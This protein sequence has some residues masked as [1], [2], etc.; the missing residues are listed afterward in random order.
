MVDIVSA[1]GFAT[2]LFVVLKRLKLEINFAPQ[3]RLSSSKA[4]CLPLM[5]W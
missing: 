2:L 5:R 3:L 1:V 4:I